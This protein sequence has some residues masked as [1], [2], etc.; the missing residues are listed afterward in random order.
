MLGHSRGGSMQRALALLALA[1]LGLTAGVAAAQD[2]YPSRPITIVAPFP[3][4]GVVD[5]TGRPLAAGLERAL[6]QP[7]VINN[8][9]G[10]AGAV[11]RQSVTISKPDGYTLLIDLV[12]ISTLPP[13]DALFGRTPTYTL[14]QFVGIAR[15]TN[16]LPLFV[17]NAEHPWKTLPELVAEIKKKPGELTYAS[18]GPY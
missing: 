12:S 3:P 5:L 2:S 9:G 11:G 18:S 16:D 1:V 15:L 7:V 14:D 8:K 10:A 4:G 6:K 13:V 17:V